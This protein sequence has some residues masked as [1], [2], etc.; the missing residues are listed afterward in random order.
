[1][2]LLPDMVKEVVEI[3]EELRGMLPQIDQFTI[4]EDETI[5]FET[6]QL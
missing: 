4:R 1:M 2:M 3:S 5:K 6:V